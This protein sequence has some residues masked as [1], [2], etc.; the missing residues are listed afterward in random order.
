VTGGGSCRHFSVR[1]YCFAAGEVHASC[2]SVRAAGALILHA[3]Y[4]AL[5]ST[6]A[7]RQSSRLVLHTPSLASRISHAGPEYGDCPAGRQPA[8]GRMA[9]PRLIILMWLRR[10]FDSIQN[11]VGIAT[12]S[13]ALG[14]PKFYGSHSK[15][16]GAIPGPFVA[17]FSTPP[18]GDMPSTH[19][20]GPIR[21]H[22]SRTIALGDSI[23]PADTVTQQPPH[24][25]M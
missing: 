14:L 20:P 24:P 12:A 5:S 15:R 3:L 13:R 23:T 17:C 6:P 10:D 21:C 25:H 18:H 11:V 22:D 9:S 7:V 8:T 1:C 16:G 2:V 19:G 4:A